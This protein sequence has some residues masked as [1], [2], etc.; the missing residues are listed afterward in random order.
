MSVSWTGATTLVLSSVAA[1][2]AVRSA[3]SWAARTVCNLRRREAAAFSGADAVDLI[4]GPAWPLLVGVARRRRF[5]AVREKVTSRASR[6]AVQ[7][8]GR[9][10]AAHFG[11]PAP[12]PDRMAF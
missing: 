9:T 6:T 10:D 5:P 8:K 7:T 3:S 2:F 12:R 4:T 11:R 1:R